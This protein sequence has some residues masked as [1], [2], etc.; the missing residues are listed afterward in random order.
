MKMTRFFAAF[1]HAVACAVLL[2]IHAGLSNADGAPAAAWKG[3]WTAS[4]HAVVQFGN[5]P[6][7]PAMKDV[8]LRQVVHIA[9]GGPQ[10]RVRFS[11]EF[12]S[13]PLTIGAASVAQ[14]GSSIRPLTFSGAPSIVIPPGAPALSDAV[15]LGVKPGQ[16]LVVSLY[17]PDETSPSTTH[18]TGMQKTEISQPGDFTQAASF[19]VA[20]SNEMRFFISAVEVLNPRAGVVVAFG[21]SI[22]DGVGSTV[23]ANRRWPDLLAERLRARKGKQA[24][25]A[26]VNQGISGNQ[27]LK[28][29][30]GVSAL[31]RFDRDVLAVPGRSHVIVLIGIN[32]IGIPGAR[33][34]GPAPTEA[35]AGPT[36]AD[37][38]VGYKQL[39]ARA[40]DHGLKIFGATLLPFAGA[41]NGYYTPEKEAVRQAVNRWIRSGEGFD[42]VIDF[43]AATRDPVQ[44]DRLLAAYD[45]G[46]HLHPSSAGYKAMADAI[47]LSLF[48]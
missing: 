16:D 32:D 12:G 48:E 15:N 41:G 19:P 37:L 13:T 25:L 35:V 30:M 20:S 27:V 28:N 6:P 39:I 40:H 44:P 33:F 42:G 8:T 22:T 7:P 9:V 11:N 31:A 17:L 4:P 45:C 38:I 5:R 43:D 36:A 29:G 23:N 26:V 24:E 14:T 18:M 34:D 1:R 47:Q 21:D 10:V 46:D 2:C 3:T